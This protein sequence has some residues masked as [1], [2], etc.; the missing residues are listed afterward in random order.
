MQTIANLHICVKIVRETGK[1]I[2][3]RALTIVTESI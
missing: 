2:T 1:L 3:S